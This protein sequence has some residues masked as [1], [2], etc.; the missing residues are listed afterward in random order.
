[1]TTSWIR[2]AGQGGQARHARVEGDSAV[3]VD[4]APWSGPRETGERLPLAGLA[5]LAPCE[6]PKIIA[7]WNN[8][9]ALAQKLGK[10]AP[11][12]PLYFIKASTSVIPG[13]EAIR[14]PPHFAGKVVFEGELGIVIGQR[15]S[16]ATAAQAQAAIFGYTAVND[17]TAIDHLTSEPDFAQWT[18]AKSYDTFG[19][20]GPAIVTG[21]DWAGA[22]VQTTV[23]GGERQNY[24][25]ADMIIP[26]ARIVELV[27]QDMTLLPG[28]VIACGTSVGVGSLKPGAV[29]RV[30][31][32][33]I[34]SL[35]NRLEG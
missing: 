23:D 25:L 32:A 26:P 2:F 34:G 14:R 24:P 8:F 27:S 1:M 11:A 35:E 22:H 31:I 4:G 30:T 12:H 15:C 6:P 13:G 20:M 16:Q 19:P 33:G 18:R 9:H 7:L 29:V 5:L 21:F 3:V 17:L 28:D 10:A